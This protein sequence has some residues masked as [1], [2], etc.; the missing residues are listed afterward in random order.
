MNKKLEEEIMKKRVI[1]MT[2]LML[3]FV[4]VTGSLAADKPQIGVIRFSNSTH[5]GWWHGVATGENLQDMLIAE[6]ASTKKFTVVERKELNAVISEQKLGASGLVRKETAPDIGKLTGAKY[7]IAGTVSAFEENTTGKNAGISVM[8]VSVGGSKGK[9]YMAVD[10]KVIDTTSG[11]IIDVRTV[12][13]T[14]DSS[15]MRLGLNLGFLSSNLGEKEK[16]P[17]GK[18]IRACIIEACQ[19]LECS[20]LEGKDASCMKDY[21]KKESKRKQKTKD[22]INLE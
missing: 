20:L 2:L 22:S 18:A 12:E 6:L 16:T 9:A 11:E 4:W 5:A 13:A 7:L 1:I 17:T 3:V 21:D 10:L 14:S 8:G 15:S 19:Y